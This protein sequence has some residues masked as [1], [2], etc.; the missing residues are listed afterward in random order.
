MFKEG[1]VALKIGQSYSKLNQADF[2]P[3]I[4]AALWQQHFY[5]DGQ[6]WWETIVITLSRWGLEYANFT[7]Y[8]TVRHRKGLS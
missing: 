3:N 6:A 5:E 2:I 1:S 7:L 4:S 8:R